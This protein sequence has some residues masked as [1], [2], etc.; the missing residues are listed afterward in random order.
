MNFYFRLIFPL[1]LLSLLGLASCGGEEN[2]NNLSELIKQIESSPYSQGYYPDSVQAAI[3]RLEQPFI[4]VDIQKAILNSKNK[5]VE[6]NLIRGL[7][8]LPGLKSE[9]NLNYYLQDKNPDWKIAAL[10]GWIVKKGRKSIPKLKSLSQDSHGAVRLAAYKGLI[11]LKDTSD[12]KYF[13]E[14]L[15][16]PH[17]DIVALCADFLI[18]YPPKSGAFNYEDLERKSVPDALVA[19][20]RIAAI[21]HNKE[22]IPFLIRMLEKS[23]HW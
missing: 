17:L 6:M 21:N 3:G 1:F 4:V 5:R 16:D 7:G 9:D 2:R 20:C 13:I 22:A 14:C 15:S 18:N 11:S 8:K 10:E 19:A 23:R 12:Q